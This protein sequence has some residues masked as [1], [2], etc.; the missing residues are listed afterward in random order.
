M[1]LGQTQNSNLALPFAYQG[2]GRMAN[3]VEDVTCIMPHMGPHLNYRQWTPII[4]NSQLIY[5]P[6]TEDTDKYLYS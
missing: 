3:Y 4:P 5:F 2:L 1:Q 6:V